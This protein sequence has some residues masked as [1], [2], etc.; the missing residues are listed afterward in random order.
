MSVVPNAT[1]H[2]RTSNID[3]NL[4]LVLVVAAALYFLLPF[5]FRKNLVD[6]DGNCIPPGPLFRLPYL[7]DYPER[8]LH[9][10]AKKFGPLYSFFLGNQLYV[11]VSDSNMA[12]ELLVNNGAIFS[13]RK[14]YF[15]KNQTILRGRAITASPY[16]ETW[17]NHR[18]IAAQ[19]LTA[20]AIQGYND[21]LD[22]EARIMIRSMYKESMQGALPIN[23]AHYTGR[24][25]LNNMLTL[26]FAT[27]TDTTADPLIQRILAMAMEFNDLTGPLS[28]L[29][30]FIEPLQ[31]LPNKMHAR[32]SK[33]H[34]DFIEVYGSMV[35]AV[36]E[37]MDAGENVP[38]CLAKVLIE[39][40]QQEKLDWEDVCMLSAAFALGGVHSTSGII[41]W[42]LALIGKHPDIQA[43]AH[44]ELDSI[45]GR[46]RWPSA[47]D[48]KDLPYIRAIIKEVLR[49]HAPFWNATPHS[50][51][52]DFV[53]N[54]MYIPK[55]T[56]VI[57]NC[58]TLHHNE[59]R[60]P[61]PYTFNPDRYIG[62]E[63]SS[64]ESAHKGNAMER[65]HWTFGAG[66]RI[67]PG[68]NVAE[69]IL[70]LAIS[71]LLWAFAVHE[72]PNEPISLEEYEGTSGRTPVPYRVH[73]VP[74]H[75]RVHTALEAEQ[76]ISRCEL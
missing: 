29:V 64:A 68:I 27:R 4:T 17:R 37:R 69:R 12:R 48:E 65:D 28:N 70:F 35:L 22:Y 26:S 31:W 74:R 19:L 13:S 15:I 41:Q 72:L 55:G 6:K 73:L 38:H 66:R 49:V 54:G 67:C 56:A 45:V 51:T 39:G 42:F 76:E 60:Y 10:W 9:A 5:F 33:L 36:K 32:A 18:K 75:D 7:P 52:E 53:Y 20:K 43:R 63:L 21:V 61:D 25:T 16:G 62:D 1:L 24:Y 46:D 23:P 40:Q 3:T 30:D 71:R 2:I 57:L 44:H 50:S 34:D 8:T 58:Y 11:V 59:A 47:E 14:Q